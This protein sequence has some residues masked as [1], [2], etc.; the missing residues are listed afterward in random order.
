M[1]IGAQNG[2]P[3]LRTEEAAGPVS[4]N[5]KHLSPRQF[6]VD[7]IHHCVVQIGFYLEF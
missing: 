3:E 5:E 6:K 1:S 4:P 2:G 7:L